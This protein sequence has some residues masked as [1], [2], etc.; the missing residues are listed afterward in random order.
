MIH[1]SSIK[2]NIPF[3]GKKNN[4]KEPETNNSTTTW[5]S[6]PRILLATA[7]CLL[8][9]NSVPAQNNTLEEKNDSI[10]QIDTM[11]QI[12]TL[13]T[14]LSIEDLRH[15]PSP[16]V[17]IA[18]KERNV[19]IVVDR[20]TNRLY[21]YDKDGDVIDGY[22]VATGKKN[23]EGESLT[24]SGIRRINHLEQWPYKYAPKSTI[25]Y[26]K[27]NAFGPHLLYL[28]IIDPKTGKELPSNGE[29]IHGNNDESSIGKYASGGCIR[30]N[31]EVITKVA[32]EAQIGDLVLIK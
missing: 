8:C 26:K 11:P 32:K 7:G 9:L 3:Q 24:H 17:T 25:R 18:G 22:L 14:Q 1:L 23:K 28:T 5:T 10:V 6:M 12:K 30:M 20:S 2:H 15:A 19:D 29:F 13:P 4:Y 31:N 16:K 21:R 27:P